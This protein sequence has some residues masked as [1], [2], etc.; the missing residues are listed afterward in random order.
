MKKYIVREVEPFSADFSFY[1]DDD[2]LTEAGGDFC[3]NLFIVGGNRISSFNG[4]VYRDICDKANEMSEMF[5]DIA[6]GGYYSSFY[7]SYKAC[8]EDNGISYTSKKCHEL[9]ELLRDFDDND[10]ESVAEFL[11]IST[12]TTSWNVVSATGYCQGDYVE[13]V[14][15]AN[16]HSRQ[17][18]KQCGEVWLGAA[19]EF[20]VIDLDENGEEQ[21]ACYGYIVSDSEAIY[22]EDYK[23]LVCELACIPE[24][25]TQLEMIDGYSTR[26]ICSY[27]TA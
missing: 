26:T 7:A 25:E 13:V 23:R 9:K 1:F 24:S 22:D 12:N 3:C 10:T 4:N 8:M 17:F 5:D 20:C 18:A 2:W 16:F 6:N 15:C 11:N 14:F 19:K 27:R 21:D